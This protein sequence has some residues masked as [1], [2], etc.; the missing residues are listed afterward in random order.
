MGRKVFLRSSSASLAWDEEVPGLILRLR[1]GDARFAFQYKHHGRTRRISLGTYGGLTLD[2][3][4]K[5][6]RG[7]YVDVRSGGDPAT[8]KREARRKRPTFAKA[9]ELYLADLR[10][11]AA[12]GAVRGKLSTATGFERL[13]RRLILPAIGTREVESLALPEIEA[14]HR[15][16]RSTPRQANAAVTVTSAVLGFAER[17]CLRPQGINPCRLVH[18]LKERARR[19]RLTLQQLSAAR[20]GAARRRSG[21]RGFFAHPCN[22]ASRCHCLAPLRARRAPAQSVAHGR[23][24]AAMG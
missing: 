13:L 20:P 24:R 5:L 3:A 15:S 22:Q 23:C 8:A 16:L 19:R 10:D 2:E 1:S 14:M 18:R 9:A 21:R 4:R 11:R 7:L 17:R 6:A 12:A